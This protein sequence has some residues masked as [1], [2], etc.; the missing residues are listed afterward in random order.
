MNIKELEEELV[1]IRPSWIIDGKDVNIWSKIHP[2]FSEHDGCVVDLGCLGWNKDFLEKSSDNWAGYFFNKKRVIGIDPQE[3]AHPEAEFFKG[4]ISD[5][6][7]K[8]K[9]SGSGIAASLVP[10]IN[11]EFN[12]IKWKEFKA[13][14]NIESISILKVNIEGSEIELFNNF[15]DSDYAEIDQIAVSFHTFIYPELEEACNACIQKII[16]Q[17]FTCIDLKIYGWKV[18]LKNRQHIESINP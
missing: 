14:F 1:Q 11:G 17:G 7:G 16:N 13:K 12:V 6:S 8:G 15:D 3:E 4:F 5:F 18:F 10:N 2:R 9:L